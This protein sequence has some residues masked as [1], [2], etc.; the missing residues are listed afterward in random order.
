MAEN[1]PNGTAQKERASRLPPAER[2]RQLTAC[3]VQVFAR[4]GL[5]NAGH[6]QVADEAGVSTPTV[7]LYLPNRQ[8]L[9]DAALD[10]VA[11]FL[12]AMVESAAATETAAGAKL[13]AVMRAFAATIDTNPDYV[14]VFLNWSTVVRDDTWPQYIV[15]QDQILDT[16]GRIIIDGVATGDLPATVDPVSGAHLVMGSAHMIAQMKFRGRSHADIDR[17]LTGLLRG[18]LSGP[19]A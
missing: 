14:K 7:F 3:A 6:A 5:G 1:K 8:A 9:I 15:F 16:L 18:A 13:L 11:A 4:Y 17:F 2:R 10:E 19:S 12:V